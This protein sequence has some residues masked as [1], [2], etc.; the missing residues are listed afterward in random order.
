M[1]RQVIIRFLILRTIGNFFVL[2]S[3]FGAVATFGPALYYEVNYRIDQFR[4][5]HYIV[6][7][8]NIKI[9]NQAI[10][11]GGELENASKSSNTQILIPKDT[12]FGIVIPKIGANAKIFPNVDTTNEN[13]YLDI[14][15]Q[16]VAHAKGTV[17][18]G[19][20]GTTYLFAH[21]TDNWWNVGRYNAIFYLLKDLS[22]GDQVIVYFKDI[23]HNYIVSE[24]KIIDG[25]DVSYITN[26][27][28][29]PEQLVLQTCWPPGTTLKRLLVIAKPVGQ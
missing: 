28:K 8:K 19:M 23:R 14:L 24:T 20:E 16:G 3:L 21:S 7:D 17:F 4:G 11:Q 26:A 5:V 27:Q 2:F 1:T 29:G 6:H 15:K 12:F 25:S 10:A 22:V 13:E 18:P 9:D